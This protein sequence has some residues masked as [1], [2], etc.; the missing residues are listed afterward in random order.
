MKKV[1]FK[2]DVMLLV[3][4]FAFACGIALIYFSLPGCD[5]VDKF[6]TIDGTPLKE[7]QLKKL[8]YHTVVLDSCE[9]LQHDATGSFT[10]KGN[11]K[12]PI[13]YANR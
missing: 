12:N 6:N 5:Q 9:Y 11:C 8:G 13:H 2:I 3:Y 4:R 7:V 1:K 10:H